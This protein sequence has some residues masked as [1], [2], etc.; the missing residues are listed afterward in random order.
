MKYTNKALF[1]GLLFAASHTVAL[2]ATDTKSIELEVI[3]DTFVQLTGSAVDGNTKNI[4][5]DSIKAGNPTNLGT[6]GISSN[7]A[8]GAGNTAD[9]TISFSTLNNYSLNHET[10]GTSLSKFLLTFQNK[11]VSDNADANKDMSI[12]CNLAP[13]ELKFAPAGAVLADG[14]IEAGVYK[15]TITL[16][17]TSP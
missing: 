1:A 17:I 12:N 3:K 13:A 2:A 7:I 9:C 15:D 8:A 6:V 10:S 14:A 5:I 11:T 4:N 16:T